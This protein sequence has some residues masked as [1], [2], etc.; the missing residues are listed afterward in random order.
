M[1]ASDTAKFIVAYRSGLMQ[2]TTF[3][4]QMNTLVARLGLKEAFRMI[5]REQDALATELGLRR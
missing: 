1:I 4:Q 2:P 3:V 5:E